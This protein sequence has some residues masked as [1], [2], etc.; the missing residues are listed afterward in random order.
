MARVPV[1]EKTRNELKEMFSGKSP[2]DRSRLVRQAAR[3]IV[4]EALEDAGAVLRRGARSGGGRRSRA[5]G[6]RRTRGARD[7]GW[8]GEPHWPA[9]ALT[10][11]SLMSIPCPGLV[12]KPAAP[13]TLVNAFFWPLARIER[14]ARNRPPKKGGRW[15]MSAMPDHLW[16]G[17]FGR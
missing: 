2:T 17:A 10:C 11:A 13:R 7:R 16:T 8:Q 4:E 14:T 1:S 6:R 12:K 15:P 3:L 5:H 9:P